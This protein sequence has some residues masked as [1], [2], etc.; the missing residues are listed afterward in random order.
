MASSLE[1]FRDAFA[2]IGLRAEALSSSYALAEN[3]FA[4]TQSA[5]GSGVKIERINRAKLE[6]EH[7][8]VPDPGGMA[9]AS[10]G[11]TISNTRIRLRQGDPLR[12]TVTYQGTDNRYH[13]FDA[14]W[15]Q[16]DAWQKGGWGDFRRRMRDRSVRDDSRLLLTSPWKLDT[17]RQLRADRKSA[18]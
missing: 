16:G 11:E 17:D 9:V 18:V 3:T 5:P 14:Y 10:S 15:V 2:P 4:A 13:N 1:H 8:A 7:V 12:G 6:V